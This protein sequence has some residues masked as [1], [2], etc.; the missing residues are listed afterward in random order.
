MYSAARS[1][2]WIW[3]QTLKLIKFLDI[4]TKE[5]F[6]SRENLKCE[7]CQHA[8]HRIPNYLYFFLQVLQKPNSNIVLFFRYLCTTFKRRCDFHRPR[9]FLLPF[10][11]TLV[12]QL[13]CLW[14]MQ[15]KVSEKQ[16]IPFW[17]FRVEGGVCVWCML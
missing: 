4:V 8:M 7:N 2:F 12:P 1:I 13:I 5:L 15:N 14:F 6:E 16:I 9:S 10:H 3:I 17:T 11:F